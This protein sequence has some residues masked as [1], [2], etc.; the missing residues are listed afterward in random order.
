MKN[1]FEKI[2]LILIILAYLLVGF[3]SVRK[4]FFAD[5][6][7]GYR[8]DWSN[9]YYDLRYCY[10]N[11][12][13][14]WQGRSLGEI[15]TYSG[16]SY[17][18]NLII[19]LFSLAGMSTVFISRIWIILL[20]S[21]SGISLYLLTR[22]FKLRNFPSFIAGLIYALSPVFFN[23]LIAGYSWYLFSYAITPLILLFFIH[24]INAKTKPSFYI[25]TILC[26]LLFALAISQ[27]HYLVMIVFLMVVYL[28]FSKGKISKKIYIF[29]FVSAICFLVH[30]SWIIPTLGQGQNKISQITSAASVLT[31]N[32]ALSADLQKEFFLTAF[33]S[34]RYFADI[35]KNNKWWQ[36]SSIFIP[37]LAFVSLIINRNKK[38][39]YFA[40]I[41]II[42]IFLAKGLNPPLEN[43]SIFI[44][45]K[46]Q[47]LSIFRQSY[48]FMFLSALGIS[49]LVG[50]SINKIRSWLR[51]AALSL[52]F[53]L[54]ILVIIIGYS[55]PMLSG[56]FSRELEPFKPNKTYDSINEQLNTNNDY[57]ILW[58]PAIGPIKQN[59]LNYSINFDPLI[60]DSA[61]KSFS[62]EGGILFFSGASTT[63]RNFLLYNLYNNI[64]T[65]NFGKI[66]S[67][68]NIENIYQRNDYESIYPS[69]SNL[70]DYPDLSKNWNNNDI[71]QKLNN[72]NGIEL[73]AKNDPVNIYKNIENKP[74]IYASQKPLITTSDLSIINSAKINNYDAFFFTDQTNNANLINEANIDDNIDKISLALS[75]LNKYQI[76]PAVYANKYFNAKDGWIRG[77]Y[78]FWYNQ[79]FAEQLNG[80]V[81]SFIKDTLEIP[82]TVEKTANYKILVKSFALDSTAKATLVIDS[83][84]FAI[85][86]NGTKDF[87]WHELANTDLNKGGYTVKLISETGNLA[88]EQIL[89]VPQDEYQNALI[90]ANNKITDSSS[91]NS[92]EN[93]VNYKKINSTKYEIEINNQ[94]SFYL[95]FSENYNLD[96]KLFDEHKKDIKAKH[97]QVNGYA[98]AFYIENT[99]KQKLSL[100]FEPQ[101][102]HIL[103]LWIAGVTFMT[104]VSIICIL[105][106]RK[107]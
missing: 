96:W 99:G 83:A 88:I 46:L 50:L 56:N 25:N 37:L 43:I 78:W 44:Y 76:N 69:I 66:L 31:W 42:G 55:Y 35:V 6:I 106:F 91:I 92:I 14:I 8:H 77:N 13:Y 52:V 28:F 51:P 58:F 22:S 82:L 12:A 19:F 89:I 3:L 87:V 17:I 9:F 85:S 57:R 4:L 102:Y 74:H 34:N 59:N 7:L 24:A 80:F 20:I 39:V 101:K 68:E 54:I 97:V 11:A 32:K 64:P 18:V 60:E 47:L 40:L 95:I 100:E 105:R 2:K 62:S 86:A 73:V 61:K 93:I 72:Q 90:E 41:A 67:L 84:Q 81:F 27:I 65:E 103:G 63:F 107:H 30:L 1:N 79:K 36:I 98:N 16:S 10:D 75:M 21:G 15:I 26:G 49:A 23:N 5:G 94:G 45:T 53:L 70:G 104:L 71:M 38:T 29:C 33:D 48:H